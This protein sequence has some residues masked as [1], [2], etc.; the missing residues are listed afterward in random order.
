MSLKFEN[1]MIFCMCISDSVWGAQS[2]ID[3]LVCTPGRLVDHLMLTKGLDLSHLE[4]LVIDEADRVL[5]NIQDNWLYHLEKHLHQ[6]RTSNKAFCNVYNVKNVHRPQR[7]LLSAT[8][9]Q[10]PE[11]LE[12]L[13]LFQPILFTSVVNKDESDD[14]E[15]RTKS[16]HST[17]FQGKYTMPSELIEKY[18]ICSL[19]SK[20]LVLYKYIKDEKLTNV[21]IFTNSIESVHRLKILLKALAPELKVREVSSKMNIKKKK[22]LMKVFESGTVDM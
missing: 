5:D 20:P 4:Y 15:S 2:R 11:K 16:I 1:H 6:D 22:K 13:N 19:E 21:L 18:I 7:F 17:Q 8:L 12:K 9:S 14:E 10:D 3:I